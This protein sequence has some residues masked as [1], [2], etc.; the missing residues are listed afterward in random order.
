M[1]K[2]DLPE[3][4]ERNEAALHLSTADELLGKALIED[5]HLEIDWSSCW[6]DQRS[7]F[8][9][10]EYI[11]VFSRRDQ[12]IYPALWPLRMFPHRTDLRSEQSLGSLV[13]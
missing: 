8:Q 5:I 10:I 6:I 3:D 11:I 9:F 1:G 12:D 7:G 4:Q 2:G 13:N